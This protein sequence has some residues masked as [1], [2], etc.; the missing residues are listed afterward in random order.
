MNLQ[1]ATSSE[2]KFD[3]LY[4][5]SCELFVFIFCLA[6]TLNHHYLF[7]QTYLYYDNS[8]LDKFTQMEK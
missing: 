7:Q 4:W 1:L 2:L 5:S 8:L 6:T 3:K